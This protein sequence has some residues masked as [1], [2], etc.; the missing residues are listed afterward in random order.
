MDEQD[1]TYPKATEGPTVP[2]VFIGGLGKHGHGAEGNQDRHGN[3]SHREVLGSEEHDP[4]LM[5]RW[6]M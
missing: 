4:V 1:A 3:G 6:C 2:Q 5:F